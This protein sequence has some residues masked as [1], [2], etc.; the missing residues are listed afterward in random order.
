[1]SIKVNVFKQIHKLIIHLNSNTDLVTTIL[2]LSAFVVPFCTL[3]DG[4][5]AVNSKIQ[6]ITLAKSTALWVVVYFG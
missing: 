1:M 4:L 6:Q 3:E 2:S 5:E